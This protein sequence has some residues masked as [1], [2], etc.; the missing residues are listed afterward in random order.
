[1]AD[2]QGPDAPVALP[3]P[4]AALAPAQQDRRARRAVV[5]AVTGFPRVLAGV[6]LMTAGTATLVLQN[7]IRVFEADAF[8]SWANRAGTSFGPTHPMASIVFIRSGPSSTTG[9]DITPECTSAFLI[10]PIL[11]LAGAMVLLARRRSTFR[12]I[13]AAACA[14]IVLFAANQLRIALIAEFVRHWGMNQGYPIAHQV[15]GSF[16]TLAAAV[17]AYVLYFVFVCRERRPAPAMRTRKLR[18]SSTT[19]SGGGTASPFPPTAPALPAWR[20]RGAELRGQDL[21]G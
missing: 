5:S 11:I 19:P 15:L 10:V 16:L 7:R 2:Q 1:M 4:A 6:A 13:I 21:R 20:A 14:T 9:L 3:A 12:I 18:R 17:T 8:A